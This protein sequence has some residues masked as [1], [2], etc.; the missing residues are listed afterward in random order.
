MRGSADPQRQRTRDRRHTATRPLR[1][2]A[3]PLFVRP[4]AK[5]FCLV[6]LGACGLN[7]Q[8]GSIQI[9]LS[10]NQKNNTPLPVGIP[11]EIPA[12][13]ASPLAI[14]PENEQPI[15]HG[16]AVSDYAQEWYSTFVRGL[17]NE[18]LFETLLAANYLDLP[19]LLELCA[20]TIGLRMMS[21]SR[22]THYFGCGAPFFHSRFVLRA[23][24]TCGAIVNHQSI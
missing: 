17:G 11:V 23:L 9:H 5:L 7:S 20:A 10:L 22:P 14:Q 6:S 4:S 15:P 8:P 2:S 1:R 16:K 24:Y 13:T 3:S 21:E 18:L 19:P 12:E